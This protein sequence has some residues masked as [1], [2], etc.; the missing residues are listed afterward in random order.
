MRREPRSGPDFDRT[1]W[2]GAGAAGGGGLAELSKVQSRW[3]VGS[4]ITTEYRDGVPYFALG[5]P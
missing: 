3:L 4:Y 2:Y 1:R 5:S